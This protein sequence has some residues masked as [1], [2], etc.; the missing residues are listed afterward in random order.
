MARKYPLSTSSQLV[1][2]RNSKSK[3]G[4]DIAPNFIIPVKTISSKNGIINVGSFDP[5]SDPNDESTRPILELECNKEKGI[6]LCQAQFQPDGQKWKVMNHQDLIQDLE[7]GNQEDFLMD[8]SKMGTP[9][10]KLGLG[11]KHRLKDGDVI[12]LSASVFAV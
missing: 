9:D 12:C 1:I 10:L 2:S 6:D 3:E 8:I 11:D 5:D 4:V 7:E